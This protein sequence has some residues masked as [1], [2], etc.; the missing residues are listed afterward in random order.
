[1]LSKWWLLL[2]KT[3]RIVAA[4]L[5]TNN[6]NIP[7]WRAIQGTL[8]G[9]YVALNALEISCPSGVYCSLYTEVHLIQKMC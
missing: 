6:G 8:Q 2:N 3:F 5:E 9:R 4:V 7:G 1:M